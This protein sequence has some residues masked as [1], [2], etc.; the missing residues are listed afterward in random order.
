[1][2]LTVLIADDDEDQAKST[3]S[4]IESEF[5]NRVCIY[6]A[7][8][9][10][11]TIG[12]LKNLATLDLLIL[13]INFKTRGGERA[14][15]DIAKVAKQEFESAGLIILTG[16]SHDLSYLEMLR[17][18]DLG[19][20]SSSWIRKG[21]PSECSAILSAV[22]KQYENFSLKESNEKPPLLRLW[23]LCT[24]S[25]NPSRSR[26]EDLETFTAALFSSIPGL[27][28]SYIN[29]RLPGEELDIILENNVK[30][31]FWLS[32]RSPLVFVEC[33]NLSQKVEHGEVT[34]FWA[35][36]HRHRNLARV[37]IIV[38]ARGFTRGGMLSP[39]ENNSVIVKISGSDIEQLLDEKTSVERWLRTLIVRGIS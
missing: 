28:V 14:G 16:Y 31:P 18:A 38:S 3:A 10:S 34:K 20:Q 9:P 13:D 15:L 12:I 27:T 23:R 21:E 37:G 39:P 19:V 36:L 6:Q 4:L 22:R 2:P 5:G 29:K 35:K 25:A 7:S 11:A 32:L 17:L 33:K 30:E 26:G 24:A 1:M 8:N